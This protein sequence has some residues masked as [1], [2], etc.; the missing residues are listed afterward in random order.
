MTE[1]GISLCL[2]NILRTLDDES[3]PVPFEWF[4]KEPHTSFQF[5]KASRFESSI[6]ER[7]KKKV[8][9]SVVGDASG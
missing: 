5:P 7:Q 6:A 9:Y 2:A 3:S 1:I 8:G 4:F